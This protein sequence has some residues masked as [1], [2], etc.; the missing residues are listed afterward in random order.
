MISAAL[1]ELVADN[2]KVAHTVGS[3][4]GPIIVMCVG[5]VAAGEAVIARLGKVGSSLKYDYNSVTK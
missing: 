3:I 4:V 2:C 5:D 1:G